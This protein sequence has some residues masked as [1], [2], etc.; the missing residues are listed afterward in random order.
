MNGLVSYEQLTYSAF[1][2][3]G[4]LFVEREREREHCTLVGK[5]NATFSIPSVAHV[6]G[7]FSFYTLYIRHFRKPFDRRLRCICC[8]E[9]WRVTLPSSPKTIRLTF[10]I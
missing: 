2:E 7:G 10:Y 9:R 1:S 8:G 6:T 5:E 3:K 4:T